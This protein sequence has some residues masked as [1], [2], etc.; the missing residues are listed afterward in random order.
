MYMSSLVV[1][2]VKCPWRI[3]EVPDSTGR[4]ADSTWVGG[5]TNDDRLRMNG[6]GLVPIALDCPPSYKLV[7]NPINYRYIYHKS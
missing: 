5:P 3:M 2:L 1:M 6:F 7:Y 4:S